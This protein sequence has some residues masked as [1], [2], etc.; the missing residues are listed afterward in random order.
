VVEGPEDQTKRTQYFIKKILQQD[1]F[2]IPDE[3][4]FKH[5]YSYDAAYV[6]E[7]LINLEPNNCA[8]NICGDDKIS[9]Q[10]YCDMIAHLLKKQSCY[11]TLPKNE[12]MKSHNKD[13]PSSYQRTLLLSNDLIKNTVDY[14][15]TSI[16]HW[17][18]I[19]IQWN[20]SHHK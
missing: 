5:V 18:P 12:F 3:V 9:I 16:N 20:L 7:Q 4:I 2:Y 17:L 1:V 13:F 14:Q 6:V 11:K 19:T 8:Y 15:F 10:A